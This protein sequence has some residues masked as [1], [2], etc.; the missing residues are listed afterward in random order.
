[1]NYN[2]PFKHIYKLEELI[3]FFASESND[4]FYLDTST[5]LIST[6]KNDNSF[7]FK[8]INKTVL[9]DNLNICISCPLTQVLTTKHQHKSAVYNYIKNYALNFLA[10]NKILPPSLHPIIGFVEKDEESKIKVVINP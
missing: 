6:I 9:E 4:I 5:G 2:S 8:A 3:T 10:E 1:M 7:A